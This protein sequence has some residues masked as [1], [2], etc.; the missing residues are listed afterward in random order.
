MTVN[1]ELKD[2]PQQGEEEWAWRSTDRAIALAYF[3]ILNAAIKTRKRKKTL[4]R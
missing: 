3:A 2:Y 1:V 4:V